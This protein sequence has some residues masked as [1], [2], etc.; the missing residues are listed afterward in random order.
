MNQA[1]S[2]IRGQ[3]PAQAQ[4]L[5]QIEGEYGHI[6]TSTREDN[7]QLQGLTVREHLAACA[8]QGLL[9]SNVENGNQQAMNVKAICE[10]A[11][12]HADELL[13]QLATIEPP[14]ASDG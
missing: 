9:A 4:P 3:Q 13:H 10:Q 5:G 12:Y 1:P 8:M 2:T 11:V 14:E 7:G 6:T